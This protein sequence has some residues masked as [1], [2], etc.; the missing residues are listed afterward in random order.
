M[1]AVTLLCHQTN[2]KDFEN[3]QMLTIL[4]VGYVSHHVNYN[5]IGSWDKLHNESPRSQKCIRQCHLH[6]IKGY[7]K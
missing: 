4:Q 2:G 5:V 1:L 3:A 7:P 6:Q